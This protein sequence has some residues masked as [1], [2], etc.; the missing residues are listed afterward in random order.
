MSAY[1]CHTVLAAVVTDRQQELHHRASHWRQAKLAEA[2]AA[3]S[4][5]DSGWSWTEL[6][7]AAR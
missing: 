3:S 5:G 4:I 2:R 1:R 6:K 7:T